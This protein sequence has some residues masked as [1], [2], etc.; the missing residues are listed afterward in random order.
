MP[1]STVVFCPKVLDD[2]QCFTPNTKCCVRRNESKPADSHSL[3]QMPNISASDHLADITKSGDNN[4]FNTSDF[5]NDPFLCPGYCVLNALQTS[6]ESPSVIIPNTSDCAQETICCDNTRE[7]IVTPKPTRRPKPRP[8]PTHT[9]TT[10]SPT[11][12][13]ATS[14]TRKECPGICI[15]NLVR[16]TCYG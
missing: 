10:G 7:P 2:I 5:Q 15:A 8:R 13:S 12:W 16:F 3:V 9:A 6:C 4:V 14:D 11:F 1:S